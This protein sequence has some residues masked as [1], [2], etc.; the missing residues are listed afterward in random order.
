MTL[1]GLGMLSS[2]SLAHAKEWSRKNKTYEHHQRTELTHCTWESNGS[3]VCQMALQ[4][5]N[6]ALGNDHYQL[7]SQNAFLI[8]VFF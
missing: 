5:G 8:F 7:A 2:F 6:L 3:S 1:S 4:V